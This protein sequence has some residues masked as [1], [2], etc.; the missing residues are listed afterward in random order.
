MLFLEVLITPLTIEGKPFTGTCG[1]WVLS[2]WSEKY[3]LSL[4]KSG[5]SILSLS[6]LRILM[7]LSFTLSFEAATIP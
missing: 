2:N 4:D 5:G 1:S 6:W 3:I 7:F